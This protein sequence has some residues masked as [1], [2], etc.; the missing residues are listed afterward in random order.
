MRNIY[1]GPGFF[2]GILFIAISA[3]AGVLFAWCAV[4][5]QLWL[6]AIFA[7]GMAWFGY[8]TAQEFLAWFAVPPQKFLNLSGDAI[9]APGSV[10]LM[11]RLI[12]LQISVLKTRKRVNFVP[13]G[14]DF[15]AFAKLTFIDGTILR[16][17][18][19]QGPFTTFSPFGK[20][21]G[22]VDVDTL[23]SKIVAISQLTGIETRRGEIHELARR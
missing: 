13:A 4:T 7:A 11:S 3:F 9:V 17:R 22:E 8:S 16:F 14:N 12:E 19:G 1:R 23:V 10:K 20:N 5:A 2:I 6:A 21:L 18:A 15:T